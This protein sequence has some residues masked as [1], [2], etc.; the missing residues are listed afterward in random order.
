M[1][2]HWM[3]QNEIIDTKREDLVVSNFGKRGKQLTIESVNANHSGEY[4]CVASNIAGSTTRTA[5]LDVNG[6]FNYVAYVRFFFFF[7]F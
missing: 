2:I 7:F 1:E 6:I 3:F 4:T 5:V